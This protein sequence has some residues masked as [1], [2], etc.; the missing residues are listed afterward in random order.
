MSILYVIRFS[1]AGKLARRCRSLV[2]TLYAA[3]VVFGV[4]VSL[5]ILY[6]FRRCPYAMRA[7]LAWAA[8]GLQCELREVVLRDKPQALRD[9]S[10]KATVPVLVLPTGKIIDESI[11]VMYWALGQ[12]DPEGL[13]QPEHE[14]TIRDLVRANDGPFKKA[15]DRYKY[16]QRHEAEFGERSAES[17][18]QAQRELAMQ[19]I[20]NLEMRLQSHTY[21]LGERISLADLALAPFVRQFAHTN[22]EWFA[23][24][25]IPAVQRWLAAFVASPRLERV[26]SK[27]EQWQEG[28]EPVIFPPV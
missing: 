2:A 22:D 18:A 23:A 6:S 17:Y 10:P 25:P 21:L 14:A 27:Y 20:A 7:R 11:D 3:L 24:Q 15:L 13:L 8:S 9:A 16:P 5:P 26:M 19:H 1:F 4:I 28:Q 12:S